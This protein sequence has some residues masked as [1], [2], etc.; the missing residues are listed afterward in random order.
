MQSLTFL[1]VVLIIVKSESVVTRTLVTT[2]RVLTDVLTTAIV[3]STLV[4]VYKC[5][6]SENTWHKLKLESTHS[7]YR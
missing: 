7:S 4:L 2:H 1:A 6:K 5:R 3:H